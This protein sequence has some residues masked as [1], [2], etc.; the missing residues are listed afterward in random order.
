[1]HHRYKLDI[2]WNPP[3]Q[4]LLPV[5]SICIPARNEEQNIRVCEQAALEQNYPDYRVVVVMMSRQMGPPK[6]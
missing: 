4:P 5:I 2:Q 1:M 6:F 3:S